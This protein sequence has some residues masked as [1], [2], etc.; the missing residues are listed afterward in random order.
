MPAPNPTPDRLCS[1]LGW[2]L[3]LLK[4]TPGV[5]KFCFLPSFF[6]AKYQVLF[7]S[8]S[9]HTY[10]ERWYC[11][12]VFHAMVRPTLLVSSVGKPP[13]REDRTSNLPQPLPERSV[14]VTE[15]S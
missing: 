10:F 8:S 13:P 1:S 5:T 4:M 14:G 7:D 9:G 12:V 6:P 15:A 11:A 2:N 3:N